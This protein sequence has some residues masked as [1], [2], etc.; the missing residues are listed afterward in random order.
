MDDW[1]ATVAS[2]LYLFT[3]EE[4]KATTFYSTNYSPDGD[5]RHAPTLRWKH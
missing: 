3:L 5:D 2:Y 4:P 1:V